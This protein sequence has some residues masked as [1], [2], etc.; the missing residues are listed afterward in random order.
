VLLLY[1]AGLRFDTIDE[2]IEDVVFPAIQ[3][4]IWDFS[5]PPFRKLIIGDQ[6]RAACR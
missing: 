5:S 3:E 2:K 6:R 1:A 4:A